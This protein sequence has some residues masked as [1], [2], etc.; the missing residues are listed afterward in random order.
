MAGVRDGVGSG[1]VRGDE[2]VDALLL[3]VGAL[4]GIFVEA[5]DCFLAE[6]FVAEKAVLGDE[7]ADAVVGLVE[8][9][10][11]LD[12]SFFGIFGS[13]RRR[14]WNHCFC[15]LKKMIQNF[16]GKHL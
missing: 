3:G 12:E 10:L 8:L 2:I 14:L 13:L 1:L 9:A 6:F 4:A 15:F 7:I 16:G 5:E 11:D